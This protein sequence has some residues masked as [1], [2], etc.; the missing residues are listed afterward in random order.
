[1]NRRRRRRALLALLLVP[2]VVR[3]GASVDLGQVVV[4]DTGSPVSRL[5]TPD[6]TVRVDASSLSLIGATHPAEVFGSVPG[7][8][9]SDNGGQESL[10]SLRSPLLTGVGACGA[11]LFL[12]DGLPIQPA[13]F[14][15]DN[16]LFWLDTEQA[17]AV[18]VVRG[19]GSVLY[20]GNALH[21]IVNVFT[22]PP[23]LEPPQRA[24]LEYGSHHYTRLKASLGYWDGARGFRA[25]A[26]AAH[27]GGF[28]A[29]SGYD[30]QKLV[31]RYDSDTTHSS[32]ET[33]L[34]I[35]NLDQ[36]TA[37]YIYGQNAY[38]DASLRDSNPT[39]NAFRDSQSVLLG[40]HWRFELAGG[41]ELDVSPYLR[42]NEMQFTEH[43]IPAEPVQTDA[44]N[45]A[46]AQFALRSRV[47][48]DTRVMYGL[49]TE[50]THGWLTEFQPAALTTSTPVQD[51]IR[52]QGLHYDFTADSRT[53]A[54]YVDLMQQWSPRWLFDGGLRLER[55][56][57]SYV[58][59][60][61]TGDT[62][63]D[64]TPCGFGGCLF[65]RPADRRDVFVNLLPKF[66][67]SWLASPRE[68]VY[69]NVG[70]GARAPQTQELYELQSHQSVADLR[71]ETLDNF[72]V[73][74]RGH[75]DWL[76]W[77]LDVYYMLKDHFIF[78]DA[79]GFNVSDGRTRH[80]G[81]EFSVDWTLNG[82][83]SLLVA[84]TYAVHSYA[85]T[86]EVSPG[87][88][89]VYGN[90]VKYAPRTQGSF[91]VRWQPDSASRLELEFRHQ[92]GYWLDES[93]QH[94]YGGED[95]V[96]LYAQRNLGRGYT[97]SVRLLNLMDAAYAEH[98][99][100]S[101]GRY[102]YFPG[103]GREYFIE[104]EKAW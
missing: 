8:Y 27:D 61:L 95:L 10:V 12:E 67:V 37:G 14:C 62:R 59:L 89:I 57:Y 99:D 103:D 77:D 64:G 50:Y 58:N 52:P 78:R 48:R 42:R 18:E 76:H 101:F 22:L 66:G 94:R 86:A 32:E 74:W 13:G 21:G 80:R 38:E 60:M 23:D 68:T 7:A 85:F 54:G 91:V 26:N 47:S 19:P 55:A 97:L 41:G 35:T 1:M 44:Q 40:Q 28:R 45:S 82:R 83:W 88:A 79:N 4:T 102:R 3:A 73:G 15:D 65:N 5:R 49:D 72:E 96:D 9:V 36:K 16:A 69:A 75:T 93:N 104:L 25:S 11:F 43:Y 81:V 39:P 17:S 31:L 29:D 92:G 33:L 84:G 24:S 71:S 70:R 2:G 100:Y 53:V 90:D 6:N 51:A 20:G 87:D 63:A 34:A 46:G 30:Q 56:Q 98:A